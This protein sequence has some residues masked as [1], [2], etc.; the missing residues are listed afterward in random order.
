[1][2]RAT[3]A[4]AQILSTSQASEPTGRSVLPKILRIASQ[5]EA[6]LGYPS[7]SKPSGSGKWGTVRAPSCWPSCA[8]D[9][10]DA[11]DSGD[12]DVESMAVW[13]TCY[14]GRYGK[15]AWYR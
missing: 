12:R 4:L 6:A 7:D 3:E 2:L 11:G 14:T 1:M 13:W 5:H 10:G 8:G 15:K 9:A